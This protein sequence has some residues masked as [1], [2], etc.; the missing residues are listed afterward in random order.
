M[1]ISSS[2]PRRA[3][4]TLIFGI[5]LLSA[6]LA[7]GFNV[8][9]GGSLESFSRASGAADIELAQ[10]G[11][12]SAWLRTEIGT[13]F[14]SYISGGLTGQASFAGLSYYPFISRARFGLFSAGDR[15]G[16]EVGRFSVAEPSGLAL[17][18]PLDGLSLR[19]R[20]SLLSLRASVGYTGLIF[21]ESSPYYASR[22]DI[23]AFENTDRL[24][25]P[26]RVIF[27]ASASFPNVLGQRLALGFTLNQD[28]WSLVDPDSLVEAGESVAGNDIN[29]VSPGGLLNTQYTSLSLSGAVIPEITYRVRGVLGTGSQ[30][31][32]VSDAYEE[33]PIVSYAANARL[34]FLLPRVLGLGLRLEGSYTSGDSYAER[35]SFTEGSFS[36]GITRSTLYTPITQT[37]I[38]RGFNPG[39]GNV[40]FGRGQITFKPLS[41]ETGNLVEVQSN[42]TGTAFFRSEV[43]PTSIISYSD[44]PSPET[45][46]PTGL[47]LGT[48]ARAAI[49]VRPS[50]DIGVSFDLSWFF[51]AAW[52]NF[53][54]DGIRENNDVYSSLYVSFSF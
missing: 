1:N 35:R 43:G 34:S 21:R 14:R 48:E 11:T 28:L 15:A 26:P 38:G 9:G 10:V 52:E 5:C 6:T 46:P 23:A 41:L 12:L 33:I 36:E 31:L 20:N 29:A 24:L 30:L 53:A 7:F 47:Y 3:L 2:C 17:T 51:P 49:N 25:G 54:L 45:D 19:L 40:F 16:V 4:R 18:G 50:S 32:Y 42:L 44:E 39:L 37:S 8:D 13:A 22:R 27:V